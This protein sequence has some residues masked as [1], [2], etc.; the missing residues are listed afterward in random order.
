[1]LHRSKH[2]PDVVG[3]RGNGDVRVDGGPGRKIGSGIADKAERTNTRPL[4]GVK[5][6]KLHF[7]R[8]Y[9]SKVRA[10]GP[11]CV[12]LYGNV[13][14]KGKVTPCTTVENKHCVLFT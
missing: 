8:K 14:G 11:L 3:V 10:T 7:A 6:R 13:Q 12:H 4:Y 2:E 1:M 9:L 5:G